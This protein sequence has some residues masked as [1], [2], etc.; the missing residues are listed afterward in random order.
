[1]K[2]IIALFFGVAMLTA[3]KTNAQAVEAGNIIIEPY[4]GFLSVTNAAFKSLN[5]NSTAKFSSIGPFGGRFEYMVSEKI[6]IGI[7]GHMQNLSLSWTDNVTDTLTGT[8]NKYNYKIYRN[9]VRIMPRINIHFGGSDKFD[10]YFGVAAGYRNN[11]WGYE[12]NDPNY[13]GD[14]TSL[15]LIPIAMRFALGGRYFFT[16]NI[17]LNMEIGLGGGTIIHGGLTFKI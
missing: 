4:Y 10:G 8:S 2:K 3:P 6:G 11:K 5:D 12:S 15:T 14:N 7:D 13:K 1:M 17:G 9:T 16:P